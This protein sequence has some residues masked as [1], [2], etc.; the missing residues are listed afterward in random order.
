LPP[1]DDALAEWQAKGWLRVHGGGRWS[2]V[3]TFEA[4]PPARDA[5]T[6]RDTAWA[7]DAAWIAAECEHNALGDWRKLYS[8]PGEIPRREKAR[9][10]C[11]S[12]VA[13]MQVAELL[14]AYA[15][16]PA[17]PE[18]AA[19]LRTGGRG[20]AWLSS[21]AGD[22]STLDFRTGADHARM[23]DDM[24]AIAR[25]ARGDGDVDAAASVMLERVRA[26]ARGGL[27]PP[28]EQKLHTESDRRNHQ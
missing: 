15:L 5:L 26:G 10:E 23:R 19:S 14:V 28:R 13:R 22:E 16:E 11:R 2:S 7:R 27:L 12:R 3:V 25:A 9:G 8:D 20:F 21:L 6:A 18:R 24:A 17:E 1:S 4:R